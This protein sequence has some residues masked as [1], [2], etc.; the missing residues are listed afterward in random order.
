MD[1]EEIVTIINLVSSVSPNRKT[2]LWAGNQ[3]NLIKKKM[4][5]DAKIVW[6]D[7]QSKVPAFKMCHVDLCTAKDGTRQL[8]IASPQYLTIS[9][10]VNVK[11]VSR[12]LYNGARPGDVTL[13][14]QND[15]I[16]QIAIQNAPQH[17]LEEF[18][19]AVKPP[20]TPPFRSNIASKYVARLVNVC[21][22][23]CVGCPTVA[24]WLLQFNKSL[25]NPRIPVCDNAWDPR[26]VLWSGTQTVAK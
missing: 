2:A 5:C 21:V 23:V 3:A 25:H 16:S 20:K 26:W 6:R 8:R 19:S 12:V 24:R 10:N 1:C 11:N 17:K 15:S 7:R 13:M 4:D 18:L 9:T 14:L 22:H